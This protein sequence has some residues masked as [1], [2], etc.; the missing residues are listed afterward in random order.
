MIT[1]VVPPLVFVSLTHARSY[2]AWS[3]PRPS[4]LSP[5]HRHSW[6]LKVFILSS[7]PKKVYEPLLP[8]KF[9]EPFQDPDRVQFLE[10]KPVSCKEGSPLWN[11]RTELSPREYILLYDVKQHASF[12]K[13]ILSLVDVPTELHSEIK[14]TVCDFWDWFDPDGPL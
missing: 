8:S 12:F 11:T 6:W 2:Y 3:P 1:C 4:S 14:Q 9:C 13:T 5:K 7:L 10:V